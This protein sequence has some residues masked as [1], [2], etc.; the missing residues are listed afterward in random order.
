M[1]D[2]H[3]H[4]KNHFGDTFGQWSRSSKKFSQVILAWKAMTTLMRPGGRCAESTHI[5]CAGTEIDFFQTLNRFA[6]Y[7]Q[8]AGMTERPSR[9]SKVIVHT[10]FIYM[11]NVRL[12][13]FLEPIAACYI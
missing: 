7:A 5:D 10:I 12:D 4:K 9:K 8:M 2:T 1:E 6:S 11:Y 3:T 13:Q